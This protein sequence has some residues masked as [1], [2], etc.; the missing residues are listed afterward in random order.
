MF[1]WRWCV[2]EITEL[3]L[4]RLWWCG[5]NNL[6][7]STLP[8]SE[9]VASEVFKVW[10]CV[11]YSSSSS[12][13]PSCAY[14][15][16]SSGKVKRGFSRLLLLFSA[17]HNFLFS[18]HF[19]HPYEVREKY[20]NKL[21]VIRRKIAVF[22]RCWW[23]LFRHQIADEGSISGRRKG[24]PLYSYT[25]DDELISDLRQFPRLKA[26]KAIGFGVSLYK[27]CWSLLSVQTKPA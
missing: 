4:L 23:N 17:L 6:R 20:E 10:K 1:T 8:A 2:S 3:L 16:I 26:F 18:P 11:I 19:C 14:R 24:A 7:S 27:Y 25:Y 15:F 12:S 21:H 22:K 9:N 13:L 5:G